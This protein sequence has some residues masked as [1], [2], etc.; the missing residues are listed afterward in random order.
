MSLRVI[1]RPDSVT[2]EMKASMIKRLLLSPVAATVRAC[3]FCVY[4]RGCETTNSLPAKKLRTS[5]AVTVFAFDLPNLL[6]GQRV[7]SPDLTSLGISPPV[8][9]KQG[10]DPFICPSL[11]CPQFRHQED[12]I[13][14]TD[15]DGSFLGTVTFPSDL[16]VF[17]DDLEGGDG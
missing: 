14:L 10:P 12:A 17:E 8:V 15:G 7:K 3:F 2:L 13:A 1:F 11:L 4:Q 5:W 6:Q 9:N 16:P